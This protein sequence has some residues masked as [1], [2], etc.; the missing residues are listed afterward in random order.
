[1]WI[2]GSSNHK[3]SNVL[4]HA[5]SQ[6]HLAAM[7]LFR[8][9]QAHSSCV[10]NPIVTS[11]IVSSM[12]KLDAVTRERMKRKFDI[13]YSMAQESLSFT[14][15]PFLLE[16]ETRHG[17]D[18]GSSYRSDVSARSFTHFI[19]ESQRQKFFKVHVK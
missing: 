2:Q 5:S 13:C 7:V 12:T 18:V 17:V 8:K 11:P 15:Y 1:M 10:V 16:L 6:Q 19:A 14:K 4:D 9:D 3:T